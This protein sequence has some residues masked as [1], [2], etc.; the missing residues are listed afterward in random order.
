MPPSLIKIMATSTI[1][2]S[3][4][5]FIGCIIAISVPKKVPDRIYSFILEFTAGLMIAIICFDLI[6]EALA[7]S[8]IM[9][10]LPSLILGILFSVAVQDFIQSNTIGGRF[11]RTGIMMFLYICA[12]DL[13]QGLAIGSGFHLSFRLGLALALSIAL[14]DIPDGITLTI[15]FKRDGMP[16]AKCLVI[17]LFTLLPLALGSFIGAYI[18][19][20]SERFIS[21]ILSFSAG[22][23]LYISLGELVTRSK[24]L[25]KGRLP[26]MGCICGILLG[27]I[28]TLYV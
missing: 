13:P 26:T 18:G 27:L 23:I 22:T 14:H 5:T 19:S 25:Y 11:T 20:I 12:K 16:K 17:S 28:I 3:M 24:N 1:L 15:P 2:G 8:T 6:V 4:G 10:V 21:A 9:L 7:I